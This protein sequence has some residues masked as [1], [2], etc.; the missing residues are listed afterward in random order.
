MFTK[1]WGI[2]NT[3]YITYVINSW[4]KDLRRKT[5]FLKYKVKKLCHIPIF[6]WSWIWWTSLCR[7]CWTF[8]WRVYCPTFSCCD[9]AGS[10]PYK[11]ISS[12]LYRSTWAD[13]SLVLFRIIINLFSLDNTCYLVPPT[14]ILYTYK[15]PNKNTRSLLDRRD[16]GTQY[17]LNAKS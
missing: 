6:P 13:R 2:K 17:Q 15:V 10:F 4:A 14:L 9:S 11:N 5:T 7:Y 1:S 3:I 12:E 16:C 8:F